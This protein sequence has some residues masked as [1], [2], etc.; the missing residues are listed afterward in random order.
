MDKLGVIGKVP[1][2]PRVIRDKRYKVWVDAKRRITALYDLD[3]DPLER[4][5]LLPTKHQ[6]LASVLEKMRRVVT[7]TPEIDGRPRYGKRLAQPWDRQH[8]K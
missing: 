7:A 5:N 2:T 8:K 4:A 3:Q 6:E 1:Y